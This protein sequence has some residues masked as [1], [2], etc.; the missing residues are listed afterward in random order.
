MRRFSAAQKGKAP[1]E[2]LAAP[3]SKSGRG[4]S[5]KYAAPPPAASNGRGRGFACPGISIGGNG[6][7]SAG[8][9]ARS[10]PSGRSV[11]ATCPPCPSLHSA[12]MA[13]GCC[14]GVSWVEVEV[15]PDGYVYLNR[16]WLTFTRARGLKGRRYLLFKYDGEMTLFV[17]IFGVEGNRLGC[18][19][20][21]A[22]RGGPVDEL[23]SNGR[24][25]SPSRG[26]TPSGRSPSENKDNS[27]DEPPRRRARASGRSPQALHHPSAPVAHVK[28]EDTD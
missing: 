17:K 15:T 10:G 8:A 22:D 13:D 27:Y 5:R 21:D 20:E 18:C 24:R 3:P 6:M 23:V 28:E 7:T 14:G 25:R 1:G 4:R 9:G 2:G 11:M 12:D 19:P 26:D 16:G